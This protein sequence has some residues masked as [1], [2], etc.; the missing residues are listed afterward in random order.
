MQTKEELK[1]CPACLTSNPYVEQ[2]ETVSG[3]QTCKIMC[4]NADCWFTVGTA[5]GWKK[6]E[7][8]QRAVKAWNK[9]KTEGND[10]AN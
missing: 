4:S 6:K 3:L 7:V 10:Y 1:A 8:Y 5:S 9:R 2:N